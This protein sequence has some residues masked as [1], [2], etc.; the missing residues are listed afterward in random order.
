ML[1][2]SQN[3]FLLILLIFC[4]GV[5]LFLSKLWGAKTHRYYYNKILQT[6]KKTR[7]SAK[8]QEKVL[9]KLHRQLKKD[10]QFFRLDEP[11]F[12]ILNE[13]LVDLR[14]T[15]RK[16]IFQKESDSLPSSLITTVLEMIDDGKIS[17]HEFESFLKL[18]NELSDLTKEQKQK[19]ITLLLKWKDDPLE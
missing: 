14:T 15:T 8:R 18:F 9:R 2:L 17:D 12:C 4:I 6:I 16:K 3:N 1:L 19:W 11:T 5:L 13:Q 10:Y 7:T